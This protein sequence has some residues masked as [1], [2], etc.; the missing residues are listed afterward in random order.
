MIVVKKRRE[1]GRKVENGPG[2]ATDYACNLRRSV[3]ALSG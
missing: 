1:E 3:D 2:G